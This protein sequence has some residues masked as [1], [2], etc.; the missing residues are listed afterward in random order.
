MAE[1]LQALICSDNWW[2][3]ARNGFPSSCLSP[4][5]KAVLDARC[6]EWPPISEDTGEMKSSRSCDE[7]PSVSCSSII[8]QLSDSTLQFVGSGFPSPTIDWSQA[9]F[10]PSS[11]CRAESI[12]HSDFQIPSQGTCPQQPAPPT[13]LK[14]FSGGIE[15]TDPNQ[16]L[17]DSFD[18]PFALFEALLQQEHQPQQPNNAN[19]GSMNFSSSPPSIQSVDTN[20]KITTSC[21][22]S[23]P[24]SKSASL[25]RQSSSSFEFAGNPTSMNHSTAAMNGF[26]QDFSPSLQAEFHVPN[27]EVKHNRSSST[28]K[29]NP[30]GCNWGSKMKKIGGEPASKR[31]RIGTPSPLPTFKVRKEKLGDRITALQQLVSPFGKTDTASV[32]FEAIEYIKFLHDQ[33]H[34]LSGPYMNNGTQIQQQ[35]QNSGKLNDNDG[36]KEDLESHG[37]CLVPISSILALANYAGTEF[38]GPM[39]GVVP[40]F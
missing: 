26:Q 32:L 19:I 14:A 29:A 6:F 34:V 3:S 18:N 39:Y 16:Q 5:S 37:L 17:F 35:Q 31:P 22:N 11:T 40:Q 36:S 2:N 24:F 30:E 10:T 21:H 9:I 15:H 20:D 28:E 23:P 12:I 4:C 25:K 27:T 13:Q 38:W 1:D 33:V 7:L 8:T